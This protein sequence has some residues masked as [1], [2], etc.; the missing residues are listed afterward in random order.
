MQRARGFFQHGGE[1]GDGLAVEIGAGGGFVNVDVGD[2]FGAEFVGELFSPF[3]GT[4][5]ADFF[6]VPA[7]DDDGAAG[8][9][10][11]LARVGRGRA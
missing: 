10:A 3:G 1:R 4:G 9:H 7:A 5:E 2:G 8:T 6:A 11:L